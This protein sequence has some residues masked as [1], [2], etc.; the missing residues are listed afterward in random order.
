MY[1]ILVDILPRRGIHIK[2]TD[3]RYRQSCSKSSRYVESV[4]R[5]NIGPFADE[6]PANCFDCKRHRKGEAFAGKRCPTRSFEID[7]A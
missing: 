7:S 2:E 6:A 1:D 5:R 4:Q 3:L